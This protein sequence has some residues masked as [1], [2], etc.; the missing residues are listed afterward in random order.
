MRLFHLPALLW[1][2]LFALL[3]PLS[4]Q[5]PTTPQHVDYGLIPK[6][7]SHFAD[8]TSAYFAG[9]WDQL[10]FLVDELK[11]GEKAPDAEIDPAKNFYL[12]VFLSRDPDGDCRLIRFLWHKPSTEAYAAR[13]PGCGEIFEIVLGAQSEIDLKTAYLS[14]ERENPL[15]A[16][17]PKL[18]R[19][20]EPAIIAMARSKTAI[21]PSEVNFEV[22]KVYLPFKRAKIK[23]ADSAVY[24]EAGLAKMVKEKAGNLADLFVGLNDKDSPLAAELNAAIQKAKPGPGTIAVMEGFRK[25]VREAYRS[26]FVAH[27]DTDAMGAA[28]PIEKEFLDM[29]D[30]TGN[31]EVTAGFDFENIPLERVSF[32]L[33][34]SFLLGRGYAERRA[35]LTDDGYYA[36][37]PP[38]NP[39]AAAIVNI[40]PIKY[41]PAAAKMSMAERVR[42]FL[43]V[44]LNPDAGFCAGTGF[45]L[46][47]GLSLNVGLA[48]MGLQVANRPHAVEVGSRI[49]TVPG[50]PMEPFRTSWKTA[51]FLGCGYNF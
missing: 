31:K 50:S 46:L 5:V 42:L 6:L 33:I 27:P 24:S 22:R 4:A 32:G 40:H 38:D 36:A 37:D 16:Q 18:M 25:V 7:E 10:Q 26:Y 29:I 44:I 47:R 17:I 45:G 11:F 28:S 49:K 2:S 1:L 3:L 43:G 12:V 41:D 14:S 51:A 39:L 8:L 15:L 23:I 35:R 9:N 34:S 30:K 48:L 20:I 19:T 21:A 13:I